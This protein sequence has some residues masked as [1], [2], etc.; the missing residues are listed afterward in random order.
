M[1][2]IP[3]GPQGPSPRDTGRAGA[4]PGAAPL[5][6]AD[7]RS[8]SNA[9]RTDDRIEL[10]DAARALHEQAEGGDPGVL[11]PARLREIASRIGEG[12]YDSE[13]VRAAVVR[14]L[15]R[16]LGLTEAGE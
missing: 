13:P 7:A 8:G 10:S 2:I 12:V 5:P 9:P 14:A 15:A 4:T 16:E 3:T 1:K 6:P 11:D